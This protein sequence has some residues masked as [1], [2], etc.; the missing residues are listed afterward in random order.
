M[1]VWHSLEDPVEAIQRGNIDTDGSVYPEQGHHWRIHHH[2]RKQQ[3]QERLPRHASRRHVPST[4]EQHENEAKARDA[5]EQQARQALRLALAQ[6]A[7]PQHL[8]HL[9]GML[10]DLALAA[11]NLDDPNARHYLEVAVLQRYRLL[12]LS[13]GS[14]REP[15]PQPIDRHSPERDE[16]YAQEREPRAHHPSRENQT[17]ELRAGKHELAELQRD[18]TEATGVAVGGHHDIAPAALV[19]ETHGKRE[20]LCEHSPHALKFH[21]ES[22]PRRQHLSGVN[23]CR[24]EKPD[25]EHDQRGNQ[26]EAADYAPRL[27]QR[28]QHFAQR[29]H[30]DA[31]KSA[32]REGRQEKRDRES[33][34]PAQ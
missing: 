22:Q 16:Q 33:R 3:A 21:A 28:D 19:K 27:A 15:L 26:Q 2:Y 29:P 24:A 31:L 12:P 34:I 9:A 17:G 4:D 13:L 20:Q 11:V 25:G 10:Q 23:P 8:A 18:L 32:L 7:A 30:H 1:D 6:D 5:L 14:L